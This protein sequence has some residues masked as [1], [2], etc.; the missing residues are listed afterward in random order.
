M[1]EKARGSTVHFLNEGK[2]DRVPLFTFSMKEKARGSTPTLHF[3]NE[4]KGEMG[5]TPTLHRI[6]EEKGEGL[7][8]QS[9]LSQ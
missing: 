2:G 8:S 4:G 3:L 5:Y 9:S 1:K 7:H 6:N